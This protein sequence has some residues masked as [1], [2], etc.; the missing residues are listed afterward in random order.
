[1]TTKSTDSLHIRAVWS[2]DIDTLDI[3]IQRAIIAQN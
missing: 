2:Q 1:M 3:K